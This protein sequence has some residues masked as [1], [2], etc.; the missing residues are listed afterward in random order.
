MAREG[1]AHPV[2][3]L[4]GVLVGEE[5]DAVRGA[6]GPH[7]LGDV[8]G[9]GRAGD[10]AEPEELPRGAS[11]GGDP[12]V[13]GSR[14]E[15]A[16]DAADGEAV[17]CPSEEAAGEVLGDALPDRE[18]LGAVEGDGGTGAAVVDEEGPLVGVGGG[19]GDRTAPGGA[20]GD[21]YAL[22][23]DGRRQRGQRPA[24]EVLADGVGDGGALPRPGA[25]GVQRARR[26]VRDDVGA[27]APADEGHGRRGADDPPVGAGEAGVEGRGEHDGRGRGRRRLLHPDPGGT[28]GEPER[29]DA[30]PG[31][32]G[33]VPGLA[34]ARGVG[35]SVE[36]GRLLV[37]GELGEQSVD[38]GGFGARRGL[39]AVPSA[40]RHGGRGRGGER[41][42]A[43]EGQEQRPL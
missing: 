4:G 3:A 41:R 1:E 26:R 7:G 28:V 8:G 39:R 17:G 38:A 36:E 33:H 16:G 35:G 2:L 37:E 21:A 20:G 10:R 22:Q 24:E 40:G 12:H 31:H 29:G 32:A 14:G 43:G 13:V 5:H 34:E 9:T 18:E 25:D 42:A 6:G 11:A 27:A 19:E 23:V 30:E 15:A